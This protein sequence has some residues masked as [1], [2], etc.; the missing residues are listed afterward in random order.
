MSAA[1]SSMAAGFGL[2]I[3][4]AGAP[5]PVQAII[6]TE[7]VRGGMGRGV[8]VQIGANLTFAVLLLALASGLALAAPGGT[9]LRAIKI[10][11][12]LFLLWVAADGIRS[13]RTGKERTSGTAALPPEARG[14]LAVVLNPGAWLFLG[15]AAS[16]LFAS[17]VHAG[18]TPSALAAAA[19]LAVGLALGDGAVVILGGVGLR[20]AGAEAVR[21]VQRGLALVIAALGIWLLVSGILG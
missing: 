17:A 18:G 10:V 11:G 16:S 4:L 6:L 9:V 12:G 8:R 14:T 3:A 21:W 7:T 13:S 2:G 5:G 19:A 1:L 20:R 15:T